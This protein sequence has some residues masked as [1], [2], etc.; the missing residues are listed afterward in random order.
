MGLAPEVVVASHSARR[1]LSAA[2][3]R[4][5]WTT[6]LPASVRSGGTPTAGGTAFASG[7][8]LGGAT[9]PTEASTGKSEASTL[10]DPRPDAAPIPVNPPLPRSMGSSRLPGLRLE[11]HRPR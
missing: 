6:G 10:A 11:L 3:P 5:T 9:D 1:P 8:D 2:R 4:W 7:A